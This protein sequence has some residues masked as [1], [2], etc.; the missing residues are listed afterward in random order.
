METEQL[1]RQFSLL[2]R[3]ISPTDTAAE[4]VDLTALEKIIFERLPGELG[5]NAPPSFPQLY[6]DFKQIGRAHV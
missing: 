2:K 6:F 5:E 4:Q 3:I 1:L